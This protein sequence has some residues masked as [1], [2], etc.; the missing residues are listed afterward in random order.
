[1]TPRERNA[2]VSA[3]A[4]AAKNDNRGSSWN[5]A[6]I[7]KKLVIIAAVIVGA[8]PFF[9]RQIPGQSL[10]VDVDLVRINATVTADK[11]H[12]TTGLQKK[13]FHV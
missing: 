7:V 6:R 12:Y 11:G 9:A 3:Q 13:D 1:M 10:K 4:V 5:T 8:A 2:H